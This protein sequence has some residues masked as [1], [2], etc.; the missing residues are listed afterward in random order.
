MISDIKS[1]MIG[2]ENVPQAWNWYRKS[3]VLEIIILCFDISLRRS[4][5][6]LFD[7]SSQ[8]D[9]YQLVDN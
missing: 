1:E 8:I 4:W 3:E 7:Y 6:A 2:F 9:Q 5:L